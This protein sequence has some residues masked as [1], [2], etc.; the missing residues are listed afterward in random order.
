M[1][2]G[3]ILKKIFLMIFFIIILYSFSFATTLELQYDGKTYDYPGPDVNLVLNGEKFV[4]TEGQMPPIIIDSRTLVPVREVFEK[5]GGK[6]DWNADERKVTVTFDETNIIL[7]LDKKEALVNGKGTTIDVPAKLINSKTMV[8]VRFISENG[9]LK[10]DWDEATTT[11][12]I[13]K[14]NDLVLSKI[15]NVSYTKIKDVDCIVIDIDNTTSFNTFELKQED[16]KT[17]RII[18]DINNSVFDF[19]YHNIEIGNDSGILQIR[20]GVQEN[21]VNRI[22]I[23]VENESNYSVVKSNDEK[24]IIIAMSSNFEYEDIVESNVDNNENIN[25]TGNKNDD[26]GNNDDIEEPEFNDDEIDNENNDVPNNT[27]ENIINSKADITSTI[28]SIKYSTASNKARIILDDKF[29]YEI[30]ELENPKRVVLEFKQSDLKLEGPSEINLKNKAIISI[31]AKEADDGS[32]IITIELASNATYEISKKTTELQF[33][34]EQP[35]YRNIEY[36][37]KDSYAE[38]ILRDVDLE[39]LS[40]L[41][42]KTTKKYTIKYS[43][44]KFDSGSGTIEIGDGFIKKISITNTKITITDSGK[45]KY[46]SSQ[47]GDDVIFKITKNTSDDEKII[48]LDAGHGGNDPGASNGDYKE[49]DYNLKILLKLKDMLENDGYTVYAT[50][51]KDETLTVNDRVY[52]ATKDY[53]EASLYVSIHHNSVDNKNYSGTLIMY[54]N[55]DTSS[56]GITNKQF[57]TYVLEELVD[58]IGTVNRGFIDVKEDDTS[59]RVLTEV[60]MPSILCEVAFISNDEELARIKTDKFQT[61]AAEGIYNGIVKTLSKMN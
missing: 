22:V 23:D 24:Q 53:P 15:N 39:Y 34:A 5:L 38:L 18:V 30:T 50:R 21:N 42:S 55:R 9:N 27:E 48:I 25:D 13:S 26:T 35:S 58:S 7:W 12:S 56:Y 45:I 52:L 29:E 10:V 3:V 44:S 14:K 32:S 57:A 46:S 43:S 36:Y 41:Q 54:C 17:Y 59:K 33:K 28:T 37:N 11:V 47:V 1:K 4:P 61:K 40:K 6:V 8:P 2:R 49:K 51:E 16:D 31:I 60:S 19:N 20:F